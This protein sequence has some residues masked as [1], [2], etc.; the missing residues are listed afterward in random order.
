MLKLLSVTETRTLS[1][2]E[3]WYGARESALP[4]D[5]WSG[6]RK[7]FDVADI[8]PDESLSANGTAPEMFVAWICSHVE[9]LSMK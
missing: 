4:A 6:C 9:M 2:M 7:M 8:L 1:T 5:V 3:A